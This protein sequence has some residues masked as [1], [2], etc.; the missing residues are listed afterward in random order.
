[1][2]RYKIPVE[3]LPDEFDENSYEGQ[4]AISVL[5]KEIM[6]IRVHASVENLLDR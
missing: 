1:M 6:K 5:G 4:F 3:N 2:E